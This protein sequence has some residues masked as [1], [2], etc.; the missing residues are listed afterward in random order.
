MAMTA[1]DKEALRK[2]GARIY[3]KEKGVYEDEALLN[4]ADRD[5]LV[6]DEKVGVI[7]KIFAR[8]VT[9]ERAQ[10]RVLEAYQVYGEGYEFPIVE[11]GKWGFGK[12]YKE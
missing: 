10:E 7:I 3:N 11:H 5:V 12:I 4:K 6:V 9:E 2:M 1:E 8:S